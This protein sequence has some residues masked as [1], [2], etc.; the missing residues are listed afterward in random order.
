M[1]NQDGFNAW[2][3]NEVFS[4]RGLGRC[5]EMCYTIQVVQPEHIKSLKEMLKMNNLITTIEPMD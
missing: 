3:D 1:E 4:G 2:Y 5:H